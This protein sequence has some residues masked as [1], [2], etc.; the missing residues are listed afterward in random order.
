MPALSA[1]AGLRASFVMQLVCAVVTLP[2]F[3]GSEVKRKDHIVV[4]EGGGAKAVGVTQDLFPS[5]PCAANAGESLLSSSSASVV[6]VGEQE[7]YD[8]GVTHDATG[9]HE[10]VCASP[11]LPSH[12]E[13]LLRSALPCMAHNI[14]YAYS[15]LALPI[16]PD[17]ASSRLRDAAGGGKEW[18]G[19]ST[20]FARVQNL[21]GGGGGGGTSSSTSTSSTS[22]ANGKTTMELSSSIGSRL[23]S[24]MTEGGERAPP[25]T[26]SRDAHRRW[27][28]IA[29]RML[30]ACLA[31]S[32]TDAYA[33]E[34]TMPVSLP[35][36]RR[37][38]AML[39]HEL[40]VVDSVHVHVLLADRVSHFLLDWAASASAHASASPSTVTPMDDW[41]AAVCMSAPLWR[42][43]GLPA[44]RAARERMERLLH[45][46]C[47]DGCYHVRRMTDDVVRT[48]YESALAVAA[49]G[50]R[51][52]QP[53]RHT[54][55]DDAA[56]T[57]VNR[58]NSSSSS[59]NRAAMSV[60]C[61]PVDGEDRP[62]DNYT[63]RRRLP[64]SG[65]LDAAVPLPGRAYEHPSAPLVISNPFES[66][67]R[68][69]LSYC[70]V[71]LVR[72][73]SDCPASLSALSTTP[74]ASWTRLLRALA[75]LVLLPHDTPR[76]GAETLLLLQRC[77]LDPARPALSADE[78]MCVYHRVLLPLVQQLAYA[79]PPFMPPS[80]WL[81]DES[82]ALVSADPGDAGRRGSVCAPVE[83]RCAAVNFLPK[84]L[85]QHADMLVSSSSSAASLWV[86][87]QS[88]LAV[89]AEV[90]YSHAAASR[91]R[92]PPP[93]R[94]PM[95]REVGEGTIDGEV[96]QEG[97]GEEAGLLQEAVEETV[98]NMVYVMATSVAARTGSVEGVANR[99]C[100]S[101][102][103]SFGQRH[104]GSLVYL[105]LPS[106][107]LTLSTVWTGRREARGLRP[108]RTWRRA[109]KKGPCPCTCTFHTGDTMIDCLYIFIYVFMYMHMYK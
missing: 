109:D 34:T 77:V 65:E 19:G 41:I 73:M 33:E 42:G 16:H 92:C 45:H 62:N 103:R 80:D 21:L 100:C 32:L 107:C 43:A 69:A 66:H 8:G 90:Y 74:R 17:N 79:N 50:S 72:A 76:E 37:I 105:S 15:V 70:H 48:L 96:A 63:F 84:P 44:T 54:R 4:E 91:H 61:D 6:V 9:E 85:L 97:G 35:R 5:Q 99:R 93:P 64:V 20:L 106:L 2:V 75:G 82:A 55:A 58:I 53:E 3:G 31:M 47:R 49:V 46:V 23:S 10:G 98:K 14:Q 86:L 38:S 18:V 7:K 39:M 29:R 57:G 108:K 28:E 36:W 13:A 104:V 59:M 26:I 102:C 52:G 30:D 67:R 101:M 83:V 78:M 25:M 56:R 87:W 22:N 12:D 11:S 27:R 40:S 89:L 71:H 68:T 51:E 1:P 95:R 94:H 60:S 88:V 24:S 81:V